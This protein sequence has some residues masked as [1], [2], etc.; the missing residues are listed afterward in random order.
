MQRPS[1]PRCAPRPI[2]ASIQRYLTTAGKES[3]NLGFAR[4]ARS[5]RCINMEVDRELGVEGRHAAV[6]DR[7]TGRHIWDRVGRLCVF[8]CDMM[9]CQS[10][11]KTAAS[12]A[13]DELGPTILSATRQIRCRRV[14][15]LASMRRCWIVA[16]LIY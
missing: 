9:Q 14:G 1:P 4:R 5:S 10:W 15:R 13:R 7:H 3:L 8:M 12:V 16:H 6:S 2:A 11:E